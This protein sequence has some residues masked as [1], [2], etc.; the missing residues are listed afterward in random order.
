MTNFSILSQSA[1]ANEGKYLKLNYTAMLTKSKC[2]YLAK[3]FPNF[4]GMFQNFFYQNINKNYDT[5]K[6]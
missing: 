2:F 1:H 5:L 3:A 6:R 4:V